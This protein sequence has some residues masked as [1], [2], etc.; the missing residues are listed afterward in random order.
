[1]K[2]RGGWTPAQWSARTR[3]TVAATLVVALLLTIGV[4]VFYFALRRTVQGQL[5]DRGLIVADGLVEYVRANDPRGALPIRDPDFSLLEVMTPRGELLAASD[6]LRGR[7]LAGLPPPTEPGDHRSYITELPGVPADVYVIVE[8]VRT[9]DGPRIVYVGAPIA[10]Y[11]MSQGFFIGALVVVVV[12]GTALASSIVAAA[13]RRA[14]RPVRVMSTELAQITGGDHGRVTVPAQQDE[15]SELAQSVN[16][17]LYRL[18]EVLARQRAFVAD[19][20]HE[21]RSPIAGLRAQMEVALQAPEDEDWPAVARAALADADRLH[22]IV[23]DLLILAKLGSGV[24]TEKRPLDLGSLA[25]EVADRRPR[26]VPVEIDAQEDV[27]VRVAPE[28]IAR[29]LTNLLDNAER[30]ARSWVRVTVAADGAEAM[31]EVLD[32]GAG[33]AREDWGRVFHRFLRLEEGRRRDRGGTGLGLPI[34]RD[35]CDAHGGT[36]VIAPSDV[37]ARLVMRL[38]LDRPSG[39][40]PA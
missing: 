24:K 10:V 7:S 35:I 11:S 14:L 19:V 37:G 32:D 2:S 9:P 12:L 15:V 34:S 22:G 23:S 5:H 17:T 4:T 16:L 30:H 8:R 25:R 38:P 40:T 31:L 33:I 39:A 13:V 1:M 36:L 28:Q 29:V 3:V 18:E 20:S 6:A 26:R 21:L 27:I